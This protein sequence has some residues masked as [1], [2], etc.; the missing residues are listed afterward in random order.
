MKD[1]HIS[2]AVL[3]LASSFAVSVIAL[4]VYLIEKDYSDE[5]LYLLL[6][7]LRYSSL[8]VCICSIFLLAAGIAG[9]IRKP[10]VL[11]FTGVILSVFFTLYG[12]GIMIIDAFIVSFTG[13]NG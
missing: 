10:S 5:T 1:K 3:I 2:P 8:L 11:S 9:L 7:V 4:I 6:T 12:A 13:G